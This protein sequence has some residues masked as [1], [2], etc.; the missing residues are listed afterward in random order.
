MQQFVLTLVGKIGFF[1]TR[2]QQ[3]GRRFVRQF[4]GE[5]HAPIFGFEVKAAGQ[6][7]RKDAYWFGEVQ[8]RVVCFR[9]ARRPAAFR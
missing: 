3:L 2:Y 6:D 7:I 1:G 9:L 5:R 4:A 8:G